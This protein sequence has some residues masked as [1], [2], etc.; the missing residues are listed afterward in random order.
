MRRSLCPDGAVVGCLR[1]RLW[2]VAG[3]ACRAQRVPR[4][5]P[6]TWTASPSHALTACVRRRHA[7]TTWPTDW[8]VA[9]TA[10]LAPAVGCALWAVPV[11]ATLTAPAASVSVR[12]LCVCPGCVRCGGVSVPVTSPSAVPGYCLGCTV[13]A[14]VAAA[15]CD[16]TVCGGQCPP[17]AAGGLCTDGSA[18]TSG[19]CGADGKCQAASCADGVMNGGEAGV[20]C[21][22]TS[23]CPRCAAGKSCGADQDCVSRHCSNS[24]CLAATCSDGRV[25]GGESG[26]DCGGSSCGGCS[27]GTTCTAARDCLSG[28][29]S[30]GVCAAASC[31]DTVLNGAET[32]VDCGGSTCFGCA[33][34]KQ[35]VSCMN[36]SGR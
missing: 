18:C 30:S 35:Y 12:P 19:V 10:A 16:G 20:D 28:V 4:A 36:P 25:N 3:R 15:A 33:A 14:C 31:S 24:K 34:G 7:T 8:K 9:S 21:G 13:G 29:C 27:A 1:S 17:C 11:S 32:D 22:G 26:V 6:S 5:A 2:T 23:A